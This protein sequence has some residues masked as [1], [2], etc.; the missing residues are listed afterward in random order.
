M[1]F[2]R[3]KLFLGQS[4]GLGNDG[5]GNQ[6]FADVM[7]QTAGS[8]QFHVFFRKLQPSRQNITDQCH[9]QTVGIGGI[10]VFPH[11]LKHIQNTDA[12]GMIRNNGKCAFQQSFHIQGCILLNDQIHIF[13]EKFDFI[14]KIFFKQMKF[15]RTFDPF[16]VGGFRFGKIRCREYIFGEECENT[17]QIQLRDELVR[18]NRALRNQKFMIQIVDI[19]CN[20]HSG[21][22][23]CDG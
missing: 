4:A 2:Y 20:N 22:Q 19:F 11:I 5:I 18:E 14:L 7:E 8:S 9:I 12:A 13:P 16:I 10:I 15:R 17:V 1:F 3:G 6:H 21:N 23:L